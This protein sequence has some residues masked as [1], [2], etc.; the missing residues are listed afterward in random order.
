MLVNKSS[1]AFHKVFLL[2]LVAVVD[3]I[4]HGSL[5]LQVSLNQVPFVFLHAHVEVLV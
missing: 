3:A 4:I 1:C 5:D 2:I